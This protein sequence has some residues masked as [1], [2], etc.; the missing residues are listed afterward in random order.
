MSTQTGMIGRTAARWRRL[1]AVA[2]VCG[3]AGMSA[4]AW[5][6]QV[7][8]MVNGEPITTYDVEQRTRFHTI[9]TRKTPSRQE[10]ID[11]L[12]NDKL[13]VNVLKRYKLE[14][15]DKEVDSAFATMSQRMKMT[16]Q[17]LTQSLAQSGVDANTLKD[18]IRSDLAWQQIVRGKFQQSLQVRDKDVLDALATR[19]ADEKEQDS[20]G[21]EYTLR[22]ILFMVVNKTE[23]E[24]ET[25]KREAEALRARFN[26]CDEGLPFARA[27]R[28]VIV[29]D[30]IRKTSADLPPVLRKVLDD[31][32]VGH[33][34][35][36]EVTQQGIEIFALC[37]RKQTTIETAVK[38]QVR[39]ELFAE[40]FQ[41]VSK[42]YLQ[43]LRR[44]AM[45]ELK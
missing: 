34:T 31:T 45:I 18:R 36:P 27:L 12:I 25:R 38:R 3:V 20:A 2:L 26:S 33:L 16:P 29:R 6:Q 5:A 35:N 22:P 9:T 41:E 17:Q 23:A 37:A 13:K 4:A 19:K 8:V 24:L 1:A 30:Q 15:T 21:F 32:T 44:Q 43:E 42:R 39:E 28:N 7:L 10:I 14:V 11:E 40:K